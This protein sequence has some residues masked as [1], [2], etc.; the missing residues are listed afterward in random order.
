MQISRE[1]NGGAILHTYADFQ[2]VAAP[3][4]DA[5]AIASVARLFSCGAMEC[6]SC[7]INYF[8]WIVVPRASSMQACLDLDCMGP[9][10]DMPKI[11]QHRTLPEGES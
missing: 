7:I 6:Y 2:P 8:T 4:V 9:K 11:G 5:N 1:P 10:I 3:A